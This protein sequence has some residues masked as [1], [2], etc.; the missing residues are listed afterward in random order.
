MTMNI[1]CKGLDGGLYFKFTCGNFS[2]TAHYSE[3]DLVTKEEWQKLFDKQDCNLIFCDSNGIVSISQ[4]TAQVTFDV[5]K[6]G[7]GGDG[8]ISI[9]VDHASCATAFVNCKAIVSMTEEQ[10]E[11][12]DMMTRLFGH[13]A[14]YATQVQQ[15]VL[16]DSSAQDNL[17]WQAIVQS[18]EHFGPDF[19]I[20]KQ[21]VRD[22]IVD[23]FCDTVEPSLIDPQLSTSLADLVRKLATHTDLKSVKA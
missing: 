1:Q 19:D 20:S 23:R 18:R 14:P 16:T 17:L 10:R 13:L 21:E 2:A 6:Y 15:S 22:Y 7:A 12:R 11:G 9:T 5:S 3:P 4:K 8:A